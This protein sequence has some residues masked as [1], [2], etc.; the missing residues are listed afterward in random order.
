MG[1]ELFWGDAH[2]NVH[3]EHMSGL[4]RT[5]S[6]ARE[7]LDI[8]PIAFYPF[9]WLDRNGLKVESVGHRDEFDPLWKKVQEAVA[10]SNDPGRFVTFLGYEWHGNRRRF[11]DHNVFYR[12]DFEPLA[13][14]P[15]LPGL[16]SHLRRHPGIAIPHH[17]AYEPGERG[18]DWR[19]HDRELSPL[20]EIC[21]SHGCSEGVLS[22]TAMN[23][24]TNMGPRASAGSIIEGL[25]R[26]HKFGIIA[27]SDSHDGYPAHWG[28]GR[29]GVWARESKR[30]KTPL[31]REAVWEAFLAGRT[32]GVTGDR[33]RL[34]FSAQGHE[35]GECFARRGAVEMN[36]EV[37]GSDA[38]DRIELIRNGDVLDTYC[39]SGRWAWP[40]R[41]SIGK[42]R[43]EFGW[44]PNREKGLPPE[45]VRY[46]GKVTVSKGR[47]LG[48]EPC[49]T[50]FDQEVR[51]LNPETVSFDIKTGQRSGLDAGQRRPSVVLEV[52][53]SRRADLTVRVQGMGRHRLTWPEAR[54]TA[55]FAG[56]R[57]SRQR[58]KDYFGLTPSTIDNL[59][60]YWH[61]AR[62][63]L[64][65]RAVPRDAYTVE[66][67]FVDRQPPPGTNF[68][69]VRVSQLN[70]QFAW[71]SP[72][73]VTRTS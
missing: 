13:D 45:E 29:F 17:T 43:L 69:Y 22:P 27:S 39:H 14:V 51:L 58:T 67:T 37:V 44:G 21:S 48:V 56:L 64:L 18:K 31:T 57:E 59:D 60:T 52:R 42:W 35:M 55:V 72:I 11:G 3:P 66:H 6:A 62:K 73:W 54:S 28:L 47:I 49:F 30:S 40:S 1:Y 46:R 32:I 36:V 26:G 5:F 20:A 65:H 7:H 23:R 24:N 41:S 10:A 50:G 19:Y 9:V 15:T 4:D 38:I 16:Y 34:G 70:G 53:A 25:R 8:F 2:V 61:N 68:Y 71:S 12:N 63:V 33:I